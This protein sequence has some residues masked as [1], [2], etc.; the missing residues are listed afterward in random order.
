MTEIV[1]VRHGQANSAATDEEG[2]DRLSDLG[3]RQ[4][5]WLGDHLAATDP[6]FDHVITGTLHRQADTARAMGYEPQVRDPRLNEMTYFD[7]AR[8]MEMQ[9]GV[10]APTTAAE[11]A[12]HLPEVMT[13]WAEG[14]LDAVP[15]S[16]DAF[17]MRVT[18]LLGELSARRGRVLV[19][20]SGGVIGMALRHVL[21]LDTGGMAQIMLQVMNSSVHRM[22]YVHERLMLA[23]FNATP[24]LDAPDRAHAR[25]FI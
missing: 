3:R 6:Q 22:S 12:R 23:G 15:E 14:R 13:M 20:T 1:I 7:L 19:V 18:E 5:A 24:H 10:P 2:Y 25:T 17:H 4:A 11:F 9:H 16:F 21:S 8:A